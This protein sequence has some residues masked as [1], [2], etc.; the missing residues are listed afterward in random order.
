MS[1]TRALLSTTRA[2]LSTTKFEP[3]A[4]VQQE[5]IEDFLPRQGGR[6]RARVRAW[7]L[8]GPA[9]TQLHRQAVQRHH[10]QHEGAEAHHHL[11]GESGGDGG[12]VSN[13]L[14]NPTLR[15][16]C[17]DSSSCSLLQPQYQLRSCVG[18][19]DKF[20]SYSAGVVHKSINPATLP[21]CPT[22]HVL[23]QLCKFSQNLVL[24]CI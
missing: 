4:K 9:A 1:T 12:S 6:V 22:A 23:S 11:D 24:R 15:K 21:C 19:R 2:S 7:R 5:P 14:G 18:V 10:Q 16:V 8:R 17:V 3:K 13:R 20:T